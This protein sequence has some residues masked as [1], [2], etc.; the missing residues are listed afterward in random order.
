MSSDSDFQDHECVNCLTM[1]IGKSMWYCGTC[2]GKLCQSC[3]D[4]HIGC[5][6]DEESHICKLCFAEHYN[7]RP[8]YCRDN[9]C[10]S[11]LNKSPK[12]KARQERAEIAFDTF[13]RTVDR[14]AWKKRHRPIDYPSKHFGKYLIDLLLSSDP[15]ERGYIDWM[16]NSSKTYTGPKAPT[17]PQF[18]AEA[19]E[20]QAASTKI[21]KQPLRKQL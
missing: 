6:D 12:F 18:L 1:H 16:L 3:D 14:E 8:R 2:N 13:K 5:A 19:R 11:C 10:T 15:F 17:F 4:L 21:R 9:D 20:L 7:S